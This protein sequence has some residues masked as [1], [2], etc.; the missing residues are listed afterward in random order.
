MH[1][2]NPSQCGYIFPHIL[3]FS[4]PHIIA[5]TQ[6]CRR[7][8][9]LSVGWPMSKM[10]CPTRTSSR[11]KYRQSTRGSRRAEAWRD[12]AWVAAGEWDEAAGASAYPLLWPPPKVRSRCDH[13]T[14]PT[15]EHPTKYREEKNGTATY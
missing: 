8:R 7:L 3:T 9:T 14:T 15:Y 6:Q 1:S 13:L 4:H 12:E 10:T 11:R 2:A 5:S